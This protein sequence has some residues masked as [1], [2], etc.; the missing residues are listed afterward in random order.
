MW[1]PALATDERSAWDENL[2]D[3][4]RVTS[5]W[6]GDRAVSRWAANAGDLG[7]EPFGSIVYDVFFVF[8]P[9]ARW[10]STPTGL[11]AS[12]LPVLGESSK[13]ASAIEQLTSSS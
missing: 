11:L 12:G 2:L 10:D 13:L 1:T 8:A 5:L 4:P 7:I 6:D 9:D 3:D